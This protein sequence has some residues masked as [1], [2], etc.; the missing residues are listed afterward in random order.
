M[1]WTHVSSCCICSWEV[2]SMLD[3]SWCPFPRLDLHQ[4]GHETF[5]SGSPTHIVHSRGQNVLNDMY[6][7]HVKGKIRGKFLNH[8]IVN[9]D[10]HVELTNM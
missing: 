6:Y 1:S 5:I 2:G 4:Q 3:R 8:M 9:F 7:S 10:I